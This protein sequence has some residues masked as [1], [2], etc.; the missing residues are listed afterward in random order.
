VSIDPE[1][2]WAGNP[3]ER[4]SGLTDVTSPSIAP[5]CAFWLVALAFGFDLLLALAFGRSLLA[6]VGVALRWA[7]AFA[8]GRWRGRYFW[9]WRLL[10]RCRIYR[11]C[12]VVASAL[13]RHP[14]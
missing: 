10:W 3:E 7:F 9:R 13:A 5:V 1:K 2:H 12:Q 8:F 4:K 14:F 6:C 11:L